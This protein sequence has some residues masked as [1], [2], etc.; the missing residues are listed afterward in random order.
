MDPKVRVFTAGT[1]VVETL[2]YLRI[3]RYTPKL[4]ILLAFDSNLGQEILAAFSHS[5]HRIY[6]EKYLK[7][8]HDCSRNISLTLSNNSCR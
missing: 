6:R 5:L 8:S 4:R 2:S 7:I 3:N 1:L